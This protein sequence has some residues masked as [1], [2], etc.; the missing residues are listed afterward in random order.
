[1]RRCLVCGTDEGITRDHVVP[2]VVLRMVLG[3][4]EYF[5]F[6]Q[7][8][9]KANIQ[10]LCG[11]CNGYKSSRVVDLRGYSGHSRL[12][13]FLEDYDIIDSVVFEEPK[14]FLEEARSWSQNRR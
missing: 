13:D 9:R 12:L 5:D 8:V 1:M 3:R 2:R 10:P 11:P 14:V 6:C 7:T 4:E